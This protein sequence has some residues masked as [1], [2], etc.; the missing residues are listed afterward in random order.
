MCGC[1]GVGVGVGVG[2]DVDAAYWHYRTARS[3]AFVCVAKAEYRDDRAVGFFAVLRSEVP[4]GFAFAALGF[5]LFVRWTRKRFQS[6]SWSL[7]PPIFG[8]EQIP[9]LLKKRKS[10]SEFLG[11]VPSDAGR[12]WRKPS[13]YVIFQDEGCSVR[14]SCAGVYG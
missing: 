12:A 4:G 3:G 11:I 5:L 2:V 8:K 7:G 1:A 9:V 14:G 6:M 13:V 10:V